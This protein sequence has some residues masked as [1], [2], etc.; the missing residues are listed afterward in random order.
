M[1]GQGAVRGVASIRRRQSALAPGPAGQMI[2]TAAVAKIGMQRD[3]GGLRCGYGV[4][5][6]RE[7][8]LFAADAEAGAHG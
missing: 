4:R 1:T 2:V 5:F 3:I 6:A 7:A 8:A